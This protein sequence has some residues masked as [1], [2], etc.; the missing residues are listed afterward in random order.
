MVEKFGTERAFRG[1]NR[2]VQSIADIYIY[3][4]IYIYN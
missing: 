4:F 3:I 2:D 1:F